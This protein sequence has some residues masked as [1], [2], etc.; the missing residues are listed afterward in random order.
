MAAGDQSTAKAVCAPLSSLQWRL[1]TAPFASLLC[2]LT[3]FF[4][5]MLLISPKSCN[6]IISLLQ[7]IDRLG[8]HLINTA[9]RLYPTTYTD[10][11]VAAIKAA[12]IAQLHEKD[13]KIEELV[14]E[15]NYAQQKRRK[16]DEEVTTLSQNLIEAE[17]KV[18]ILQNKLDTAL[19]TDDKRE[20]AAL[21]L[22][23]ASADDENKDLQSEVKNL[24]I[25]LAHEKAN[26]TSFKERLQKLSGEYQDVKV[27]HEKELSAVES[28]KSKLQSVIDALVLESLPYKKLLETLFSM[29]EASGD[30][31]TLAVAFARYLHADGVS[32]AALGIDKRRMDM[33]WEY[34]QAGQGEWCGVQPQRVERGFRAVGRPGG[35]G[36]GASWYG[37]PV[38]GNYQQESCGIGGGAGDGFS[39]LGA[40]QK[41]DDG[42]GVAGGFSILGAAAA[43]KNDRSYS[44]FANG[45]GDVD[46]PLKKMPRW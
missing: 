14:Q 1:I 15:R 24:E 18:E 6:I 12:Y 39:I 36:A 26:A 19:T 46:G 37:A 10:A 38:S 45:D 40:A 2:L 29:S 42:I 25:Y 5:I 22:D 9:S 16:P 17:T 35:V 44:E 32:L 33:L 21:E 8:T 3:T 34:V 11:N 41:Q 7:T 43:K 28:Q 23:L 30:Q 20:I 4:F 13:R 27:S 31:L